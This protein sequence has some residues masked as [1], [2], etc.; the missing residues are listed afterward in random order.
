MI[1]WLREGHISR[2]GR[3]TARDAQLAGGAGSCA[4]EERLQTLTRGVAKRADSWDQQSWVD[5]LTTC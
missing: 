2:R 3:P 5:S 1:D 4:V